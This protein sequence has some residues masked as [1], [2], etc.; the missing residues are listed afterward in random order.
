MEKIQYFKP[1]DKSIFERAKKAEN[2][3]PTLKDIKAMA[4]DTI[5]NV[6]DYIPDKKQ[7]QKAVKDARETIIQVEE[8]KEK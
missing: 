6:K 2:S 8:E 4:Q 1:K 3:H 7:Q 5:D